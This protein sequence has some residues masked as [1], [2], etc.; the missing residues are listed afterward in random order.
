[1]GWRERY[2]QAS[3]RR[4][5]FFVER[6]SDSFGRKLVTHQFPEQDVPYSEDLGR[7]P[8]TYNVIGY[9]L[10]DD[11]L[12]QRDDLLAA[13]EGNGTVGE[14]V[15]PYLGTINVQLISINFTQDNTEN[16][17]VRF[18]MSCVESGE[19]F[20]PAATI[21][22]KFANADQRIQAL[23]NAQAVLYGIYDLTTIPQ[24]KVDEIFAIVDEGLATIE[25]ARLVVASVAS[26]RRIL[27][28]AKNSVANLVTNITDLGESF[29]DIFSF[30]TFPDGLYSQDTGLSEDNEDNP[31]TED[32]GVNQFNEFR[33]LWEY[34]PA[35]TSDSA[36]AIV[37]YYTQVA[38][39]SAAALVPVIT[40]DSLNQAEQARDTV[41][42]QIN[43][44][45]DQD[46]EVNLAGSL[47]DLRTT[48]IDDIEE[49][50]INLARIRELTL[51][52]SIPALVLLYDLYGNVNQ[53]QEII[54]RNQVENPGFVPG[55]EPIEVL[56]DV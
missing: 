54:N 39:I 50:G 26:Y 25:E 47:R 20:F 32:N 45:L 14:L 8:R 55:G 42:A 5:P 53:E 28:N 12:E 38:T 34:A 27:D 1:M 35:T 23:Q 22:Q 15:H 2:L 17:I 30:G 48:V 13:C 4:V 31:A 56:I 46:L 49:R 24:F 52:E 37:D 33:N 3:F 19:E 21:S 18:N 11:Y 43:R 51:G 6:T 41:V 44:L 36:Q 16:R 9:L 10:G 40:F 29:A 7:S